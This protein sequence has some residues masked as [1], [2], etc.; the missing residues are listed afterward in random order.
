[1]FHVTAERGGANFW[2][3]PQLPAPFFQKPMSAMVCKNVSRETIL[4]LWGISSPK[5]PD[6][7][8]RWSEF[9]AYATTARASFSKTDDRLV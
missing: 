4:F 7:R 3:M 6:H 8:T 5:P 9:L 2:R 1:M